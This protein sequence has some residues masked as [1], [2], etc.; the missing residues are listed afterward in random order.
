MPVKVL[1]FGQLKDIAGRSADSMEVASGAT[2]QDVFDHYARQF[3]RLDRLSASIVMARNQR[4]SP[5]SE[6]VA[7]G[8]EIAFL[9]RS[10]AAV[11]ASQT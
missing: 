11:A 6:H 9:P 10:A 8:D 3:P 7:D 2:L 4:F 5:R 1:F